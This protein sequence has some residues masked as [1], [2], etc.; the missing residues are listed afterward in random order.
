VIDDVIHA[1]ILQLIEA[2]VHGMLGEPRLILPP[3]ETLLLRGAQDF[4][5]DQQ[6]SR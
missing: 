5:I 4:S 2:P 6:A 1:V 3:G